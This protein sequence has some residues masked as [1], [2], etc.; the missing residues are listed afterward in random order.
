MLG[1]AGLYS[2][3]CNSRT[4][5]NVECLHKKYCTYKEDYVITTNGILE[6]KKTYKSLWVWGNLGKLVLQ[7]RLKHEQKKEM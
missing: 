7:V 6:M 5:V 2:N 1:K 4:H 3:Y